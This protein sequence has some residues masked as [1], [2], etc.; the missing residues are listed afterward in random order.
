MGLNIQNRRKVC[1]HDLY[2]NRKKISWGEIQGEDVPKVSRKDRGQL[3]MALKR[4][5]DGSRRRAF[6]NTKH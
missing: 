2:F 6:E 1:R 5:N 4:G 3:A